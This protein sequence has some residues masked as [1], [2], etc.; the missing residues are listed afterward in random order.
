VD[1]E[2]FRELTQ[3][4]VYFVTLLSKLAD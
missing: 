1:Y 3:E 4:E 2:W